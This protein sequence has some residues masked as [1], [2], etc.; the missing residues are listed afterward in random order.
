MHWF[1]G[2]NKVT[3]RNTNGKLEVQG[4]SLQYSKQN[5]SAWEVVRIQTTVKGQMKNWS[6]CPFISMKKP[7]YFSSIHT[8]KISWVA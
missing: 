2:V 3:R 1:V 8:E 7:V 5:T 4:Q 6:D